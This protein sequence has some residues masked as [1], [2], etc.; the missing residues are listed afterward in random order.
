[1]SF[2]SR[3][4]NIIQ[5]ATN[6]R[7]LMTPSPIRIL[8]VVW[9]TV[10]HVPDSMCDMLKCVTCQAVVPSWLWVWVAHNNLYST[11]WHIPTGCDVVGRYSMYR[12]RR[13]LHWGYCPLKVNSLYRFDAER[14]SQYCHPSLT[15]CLLNTHNTWSCLSH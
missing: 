13:L 10:R 1:M 7:A 9:I 5:C 4:S 12:T 15:W 3:I 11:F 14:S 8:Y 2:Y 6:D